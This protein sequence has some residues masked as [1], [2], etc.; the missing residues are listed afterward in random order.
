MAPLLKMRVG[1]S[2]AVHIIA[3]PSVPSPPWPPCSGWHTVQSDL[4]SLPSIA[5]ALLPLSFEPLPIPFPQLPCTAKQPNMAEVT[6]M[7]N[8][9]GGP[10]ALQAYSHPFP[11]PSS[12]P[13]VCN[14]CTIGGS[15]SLVPARPVSSAILPRAYRGCLRAPENHQWQ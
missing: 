15:V 8:Q 3:G 13:P 9:L 10:A 2:R 6:M 11:C 14:R 4:P 12:C 5:A 7:I 1:T